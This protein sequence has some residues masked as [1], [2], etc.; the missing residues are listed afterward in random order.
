MKCTEA[1]CWDVRATRKRV[2]EVGCRAAPHL[3]RV[4]A[5]KCTQD[6]TSAYR[7]KLGVT[8]VLAVLR[9]QI[10]VHTETYDVSA[11]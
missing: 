1:S 4:E 7:R 11:L 8:M 2:T 6:R 5:G 10:A 3:T 9:V